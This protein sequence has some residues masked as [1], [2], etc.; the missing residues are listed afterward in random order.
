MLRFLFLLG[1]IGIGLTLLY[2]YIKVN[3]LRQSVIGKPTINTAIWITGKI[4][5][6]LPSV[7]ILLK[8]AGWDVSMI[9]SPW[10]LEIIAVIIFIE[11]VLLFCAALFHL[12]ES[13]RVG[14]PEPGSTPL[15]TS[16][17]FAFSRN[18]IYLSLMI[19]G[20]SANLYVPHLLNLLF[21]MV[22]FLIH[23]YIILAEEHFL[24]ANFGTAWEQYRKKTGRYF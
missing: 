1:F 16:G 12:G 10:W 17:L 14:L 22:G 9:R 11:S 13:I 15:K 3:G 23:H 18:P 7:F 8:I 20:F 5:I 2:S 19:L 24:K 6:F 4:L 21:Y